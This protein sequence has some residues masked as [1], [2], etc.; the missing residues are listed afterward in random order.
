MDDLLIVIGPA[1]HLEALRDKIVRL[2]ERPWEAV[3]VLAVEEGS[4]HAVAILR[5]WSPRC[6][7]EGADEAAADELLKAERFGA[8]MLCA[9]VGSWEYLEPCERG[10][11]EVA[12]GRVVQCW[13]RREVK[14][15]ACGG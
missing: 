9:L 15:V 7:I 13:S 12:R 14:E 11:G 1:V 8:A 4:P 10:E 6:E 3:A 5:P 2:P